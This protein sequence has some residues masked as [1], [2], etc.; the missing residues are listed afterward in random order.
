MIHEMHDEEETD[1]S[2]G[3]VVEEQPSSL[4]TVRKTIVLVGGTLVDVQDVP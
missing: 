1:T 2:V 3:T 4:P